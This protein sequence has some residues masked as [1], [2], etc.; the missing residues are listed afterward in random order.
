MYIYN[1]HCHKCIIAVHVTN[2]L[3]ESYLLNCVTCVSEL[4]KYIYLFL[5]SVYH[6]ELILKCKVKY[7]SSMTIFIF[8]RTIAENY[9]NI[10]IMESFFEYYE[11]VIISVYA[12]SN[13]S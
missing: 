7:I 13:L 5:L 2:Q 8:N 10:S 9:I 12:W 4:W 3:N 11:L 6:N 1:V